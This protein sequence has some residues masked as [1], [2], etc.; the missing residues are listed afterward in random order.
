MRCENL[1]PPEAMPYVNVTNKHFD[2]GDYPASVRK[3]MEMIG[4]PAIRAR[5]KAGPQAAPMSAW[6]S[7]PTPSNRRTAP[8]CSPRGARR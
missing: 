3:A 4:L 2:G 7:A 1:V 6:V 8:R 5:Q